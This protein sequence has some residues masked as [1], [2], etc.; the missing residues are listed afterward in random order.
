MKM[1]LKLILVFFMLGLSTACTNTDGNR[2]TDNSNIEID[3]LNE[4]I[5]HSG[6]TPDELYQQYV[7]G[8]INSWLDMGE[9]SSQEETEYYKNLI[10]QEVED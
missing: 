1:G 10:K 9:F 6:K 4:S 7:D 5:E 3:E 2:D 8:Q